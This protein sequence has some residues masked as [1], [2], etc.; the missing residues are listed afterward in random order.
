MLLFLA[1]L[2][3]LSC[4]KEDP[5][6]EFLNDWDEDISF[7][8]TT[9]KSEHYELFSKISEEEFNHDIEQLRLLT[10]TLSDAEIN[11]E[12]LLILSKI[13]DSHTNISSNK[14]FDILPFKFEWLL[15]G[16]LLTHVSS[17]HEDHLGQKILKINNIDI[18]SIAN[19]FRSVVTY[20]NE[21]C[22]KEFLVYYMRIPQIY[23]YL[24]Y[25]YSESTISLTLENG[26]TIVIEP[27]SEPMSS[28]YST[29]SLPL[30]LSNTSNYYWSKVLSDYDMLYIQYNRAKENSNQSFESFTSQVVST[31]DNN[32][33]IQ[34]VVLDLRLNS[35]G[36][37]LIARPLIE[38]LKTYVDDD[39]LSNEN[40][41]LIIGRKTFSSGVLN[42]IELQNAIDPI[43]IG[44]PSGGKP[45]HYG[46]VKTFILPNSHLKIRYSTKY[47][48]W[49]PGDPPSLLPEIVIEQSSESLLSGEDPVMDFIGS[50]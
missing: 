32:E 19:T 31:I 42:A 15:D 35:G 11:I 28:L 2:V 26:S 9:L 16:F 43:I 23:N 8:A 47:F 6:P 21:Y 4:S 25:G 7:F 34:K 39:R 49:Y 48:N 45:N 1:T 10:S 30:Y 36:N 44:E 17:E 3:F 20:E 18:L 37:S 38:K 50:N 46:E 5:V 40:I 13:G 22:F 41:Y 27:S 29:I 12:L 24:D 14:Y 33:E